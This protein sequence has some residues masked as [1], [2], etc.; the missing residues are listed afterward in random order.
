MDVKCGSS[1]SSDDC[2]SVH[3]SLVLQIV[4]SIYVVVSLVFLGLYLGMYILQ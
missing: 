2:G 4:I 3:K 1:S